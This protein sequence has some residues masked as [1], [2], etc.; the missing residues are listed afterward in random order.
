MAYFP[1]FVELEGRSGLIIGGGRT[2]LGKVRRLLDYGPRLTVVSPDILPELEILPDV[3][4][5]RKTF[6]AGDLDENPAF[7][8]AATNLPQVN[9]EVAALCRERHIPVN[10]VD[11]P[12]ECSFLFPSLIR[13][14][15]LSIGISTSGTSP[16]AAIFLKNTISEALPGFIGEILAWL[17]ES[18]E[19]IQ[20][21]VT[22]EKLR[23][24]VFRHLF[25][26]SLCLGR[27]MTQEE[28]NILIGLIETAHGRDDWC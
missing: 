25:E 3:T 24:A 2:A 1:F 19:Q 10:V 5:L 15:P 13:N 14:G 27:P 6:D 4:V 7:A 12:E 8:I 28:A 23:K 18:R 16:N 26:E 21:R 20:S 11:T 22:S 9:R 17:G